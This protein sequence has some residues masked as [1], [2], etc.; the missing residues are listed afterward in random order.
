ML[1]CAQ[2]CSLMSSAACSSLLRSGIGGPHSYWISLRSV[3]PHSPP[4]SRGGLG[5][6]TPA[7]RCSAAL[8]I[9]SRSWLPSFGGGQTSLPATHSSWLLSAVPARSSRLKGFLHNGQ[10]SVS[11]AHS[12]IQMKQKECRQTSTQV[13]FSRSPRQMGHRPSAAAVSDGPAGGS[14]LMLPLVA[15]SLL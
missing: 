4:S 12:Q 11:L 6:S 10:V 1:P 3:C 14:R 8:G 15:E 13:A 5:V 7:S 2:W 9:C